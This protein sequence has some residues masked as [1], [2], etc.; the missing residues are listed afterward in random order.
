MPFGESF[1]D[2]RTN[3][4]IRCKFTTKEEDLETGYQYFGAR[5][6]SSE[7]SVWLSVDPLADKYPSMSPFM[8]TAGNPVMLVDPDGRK[9]WISGLKKEYSIGMKYSGDNKFVGTVV[10]ILNKIGGTKAG[11]IVLSSLI[12][13]K[14]NYTLVNEVPTDDNGNKMSA[15]RFKPS[16]NGGGTLQVGILMNKGPVKLGVGQKIGTVAHEFFHAY[17][18]ENGRNPGTINGEVGAYLFQDVISSSFGYM[19]SGYGTFTKD[20]GIYKKAMF[21]LFFKGN[22]K[23][24]FGAN[25]KTALDHFKTGSIANNGSNP[26]KYDKHK[27][28]PKYRPL[29]INFIPAE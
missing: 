12:K 20:G 17:Q 3:H 27:I 10:G 21:S 24:N 25:Y 15:A 4:D 18:K 22:T 19:T 16:K 2:Q 28:D 14:N 9:I 11:K 26:G 1:I 7:L 13:S 5:Y 23:G 8:Y 6:Y 29:I